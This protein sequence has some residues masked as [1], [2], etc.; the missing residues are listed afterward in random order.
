MKFRIRSL[1]SV[2]WVTAE[3]VTQQV[4]L[5]LLFAI[6]AP[7]LGPRPYG[8]FAIVMVVVGFCDFVL[9]EGA[10]EA[11]VTVDALDPQHTATA[12]LATGVLS[13]I[14]SVVLIAVAP[15][16]GY[17]FDDRELTWL[18]WALVP[19]PALSLLCAV[20]IAILRRSFQY[21]QLA[22]RTIIGLIFGGLVGLVL[23]LEGAGVWALIV[24]VLVQRVVE[25]VV[26]WISVQQK[27]RVG[28]SRIHYMDMHSV[29]INVFIG[30]CMIFV[31][32]QLPRIIIGYILGPVS[33]GLF[34]LANR[35]L[36]TILS[37]I[38]FPRT[39]V[40]R[41]ELRS[42]SPATTEFQNGFARMVQD[43][44]LL[45]FP[46]LFGSAVV[47]PNLFQ[48]WLDPRWLP[49]IIPSQLL[50]LSGLPLVLSYCLDVTFLATNNSAVFT[51]MATLQAVSI[52]L[53]VVCAGPF[54]LDVTC[55]ALAVRPWLL[56]PIYLSIFHKKCLM[57]PL[58]VLRLISQP[59]AAAVIM[60]GILCLPVGRPAW[61]D[62]KFEFVQL[63]ACGGAI[64]ALYLYRFSRTQLR[65]AVLNL[66]SRRS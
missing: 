64:Y 57:A 9:G 32:G 31:N 6:L 43:V 40:G 38:I 35:F 23:A 19:L 18:I 51:R 28:W 17:L 62:A 45:A 30:R 5:L 56:T 37:V 41:V 59:F 26:A 11:L 34:T 8:L 54:G 48:L 25:V 58:R 66:V 27:F 42:L 39:T 24:Q 7:L 10:I 14:T 63:V 16:V 1:S 3:K 46:I 55:L 47:M 20:P 33:L 49:G 13:L 4:L 52:V 65:A 21:R 15:L 61:M 50:I 36:E 53:T 44:A 60:A 22:I 29:S 2:G 12:N